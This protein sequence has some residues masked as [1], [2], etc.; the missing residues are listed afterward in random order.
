MRNVLQKM[1]NGVPCRSQILR[2]VWFTETGHKAG[3]SKS[4]HIISVSTKESTGNTKKIAGDTKTRKK[5]VL[6][7][8]MPKPGSSGSSSNGQFDNW[9]SD[10]GDL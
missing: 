6:I 2:K 9:F 7:S 4:D 10:P 3:G 8:S 5:S 1:W